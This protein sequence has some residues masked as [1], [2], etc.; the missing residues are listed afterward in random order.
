[1]GSDSVL[2]SSNVAQPWDGDNIYLEGAIVSA[3]VA[4]NLQL[5][6]SL[7]NQTI[8]TSGETNATTNPLSATQTTDGN[9]S[10]FTDPGKQDVISALNR[11]S[12]YTALDL[13][14]RDFS[15]PT[16]T[17][18]AD[19]TVT[20][21]ATRTLADGTTSSTSWTTGGGTTPAHASL[22]VG[23]GVSPTSRQ[24]GL[25]STLVTGTPTATIRDAG[26]GDVVHSITITSTHSTLRSTGVGLINNDSQFT[27][28][29]ASG[30]TPQVVTFTCAF[31][32]D[33]TVGTVSCLL[34]TSPSPRDS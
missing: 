4:D 22:Q 26:S 11:D 29:T 18:N 5:F 34:Y 7:R 3:G 19:G 14:I 12:V 13:D 23:F 16:G 27:W 20:Y 21:T 10:Q 24:E 9:W 33:Y 1:M 15:I 30:D 2:I 25:A 17:T 32:V 6:R 28:A 31:T 8:A